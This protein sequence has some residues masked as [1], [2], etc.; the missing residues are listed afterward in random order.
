M[1]KNLENGHPLTWTEI[2]RMDLKGNIVEILQCAPS[3]N[4]SFP[5]SFTR[6]ILTKLEV[7][8]NQ[9]VTLSLQQSWKC[10][11][12]GIEVLLVWKKTPDETISC[13]R[14]Q[15]RPGIMSPWLDDGKVVWFRL[16]DYREVTIYPHECVP[17][18]NLPFLFRTAEEVC[19]EKA[20]Y[21]RNIENAISLISSHRKRN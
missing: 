3:G 9:L 12:T 18:Q 16:S 20:S 17:H 13:D 10:K 14:A 19:S 4:L 1:P 8:S 5:H 2:E 7:S 15:T 11:A 6:G 21:Q